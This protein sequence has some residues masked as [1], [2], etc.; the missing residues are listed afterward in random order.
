MKMKKEEYPISKYVGSF[1]KGEWVF[2]KMFDG[3]YEDAL[4]EIE[5][6]QLINP[7]TGRKK[8]RYR[9]WDERE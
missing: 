8:N 2:V 3:K 1:P 9:I 5:N 6:L 7:K 4:K